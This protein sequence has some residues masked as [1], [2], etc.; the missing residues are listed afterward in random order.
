MDLPPRQFVTALAAVW[1]CAAMARH[2]DS[3][4]LV[5]PR[6]S[7]S[8]IAVLLW[9]VLSISTSGFAALPGAAAPFKP[10]PVPPQAALH[11]RMRF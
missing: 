7:R 9:D 6:P 11:A 3:R 5:V 1:S 10:P 2:L 4:R 8:I